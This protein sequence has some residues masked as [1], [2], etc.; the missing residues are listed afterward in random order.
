MLT[1]TVPV[2]EVVGYNLI[3]GPLA[4]ADKDAALVARKTYQTEIC[5]IAQRAGKKVSAVLKAIGDLLVSV[6]DTNPWNAHQAKYRIEYPKPRHSNCD[7][8][9]DSITA[10]DELFKHLSA[11]ELTDPLV[12][13]H[14]TAELMTWYCKQ[15]KLAVDKRKA[16]GHGMALLRKV[17][18][19][20]IHQS[21]S[22]SNTYNIDIFG[23]AVD[24]FTDTA[25]I[26]GSSKPFSDMNTMY[27]GDIQ[28]DLFDWKARLRN[29]QMEHCRHAN[30]QDEATQ[31]MHIDFTRVKNESNRDGM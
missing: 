20:F 2:R 5:E 4:Q 22:I 10:D 28:Q 26:W 7:L 15:Q 14:A 25:H 16:V 6:R 13:A 3:P 11:E 23:Y 21:T 30:A 9:F 18:E 8:H 12:K 29:V 17:A 19:P 24:R 31:A 27:P 1:E